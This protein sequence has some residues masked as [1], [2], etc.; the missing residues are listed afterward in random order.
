M[1][2]VEFIGSELTGTNQLTV[3]AFPSLEIPRFKSMHGWEVWSTK[4]EVSDVVFPCLRELQI[5]DCPKLIEVSL[6][7]LLLVLPCLRKL[8]IVNF[9]KM[10][11]FSPEALPALEYLHFED[12]LGWK[13]WSTNDAVFP[14]L[15][16]LHIN[17]CP[18]LID[19]SAEALP[20]L[21]VLEIAGCG[22]GVLRSLVRAASS[23]IKLDIKAYWGC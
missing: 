12:M 16:K 1:P 17:N 21:R 23:I 15:R 10:I 22:N 14:C 20:P 19:V 2:N 11:E 4:N 3:A 9:L 8:V 7:T 5:E 6:K 13:T 18:E